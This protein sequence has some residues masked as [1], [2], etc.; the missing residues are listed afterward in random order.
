MNESLVY[1]LPLIAISACFTTVPFIAYNAY[2][3][4]LHKSIY[5]K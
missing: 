5:N 1:S 3:G 2:P 4:L